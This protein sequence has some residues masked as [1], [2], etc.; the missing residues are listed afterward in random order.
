MENDPNKKESKGKRLFKKA[1][2]RNSKSNNSSQQSALEQSA[3][4][5][6]SKSFENKQQSEEVNDSTPLPTP[7]GPHE[8]AEHNEA[9]KHR[10]DDKPRAQ[11]LTLRNVGPFDVVK[12]KKIV[13]IQEKH[14]QVFGS[15]PDQP[16]LKSPQDTVKQKDYFL[17][18][19]TSKRGVKRVCF[20]CLR[21]NNQT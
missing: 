11:E 9:Q 8:R 2:R 14:N 3:S 17:E 6:R 7:E 16:K 15:S 12:G 18:P 4:V 1:I 10:P 13:D 5:S 19:E 21:K 20:L